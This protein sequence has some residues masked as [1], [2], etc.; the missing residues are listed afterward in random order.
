[1][2]QDVRRG[3]WL[4]GVCAEMHADDFELEMTSS[5]PTIAEASQIS[6]LAIPVTLSE[7]LMP[8]S[9]LMSTSQTAMST[10]YAR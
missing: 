7:G 5:P 4:R 3:D 9:M 2:S 8:Q 6:R 1:M 10:M